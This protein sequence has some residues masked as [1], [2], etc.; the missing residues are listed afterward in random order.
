MPV[1]APA[2]LTRQQHQDQVAKLAHVREQLARLD[3]AE[4]DQRAHR[5]RT[6]PRVDAALAAVRAAE[7]ELEAARREAATGDSLGIAAARRRGDLQREA[8]QLEAD[9]A[10]SPWADR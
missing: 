10:D 5:E 9:L 2:I 4:A 3:Q 1:N 6:K 8:E 7:Q